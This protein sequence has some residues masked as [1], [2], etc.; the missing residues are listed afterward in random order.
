MT[1][2]E[3]LQAIRQAEADLAFALAQGNGYA[4][5]EAVERLAR[6]ESD[7]YAATRTPK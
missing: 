5:D 3:L 4:E 6:L 2:E 7:L 1:T